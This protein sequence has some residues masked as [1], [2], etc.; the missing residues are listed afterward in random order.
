MHGRRH[1]SRHQGDCD[2]VF[3][4]LIR[5]LNVNHTSTQLSAPTRSAAGAAGSASRGRRRTGG[6]LFPPARL[7]AGRG[8]VQFTR[9]F[10]YGA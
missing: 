4:L 1:L 6:R 9:F 3:N 10:P 5:G 7:G 2:T 8:L